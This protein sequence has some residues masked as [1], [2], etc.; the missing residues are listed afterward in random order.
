MFAS[1]SWLHNL[2][3]WEGDLLGAGLRAI[4]NGYSEQPYQS[5]R[6]TDHV[7]VR[8]KL[9]AIKNEANQTEKEQR[10]VR[11]ALVN[12]FSRLRTDAFFAI[13]S[14]VRLRSRLS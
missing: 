6:Q 13:C 3:H 8:W 7:K 12:F 4:C 14:S 10:R 9:R 1:D 5:Q 2:C 11:V